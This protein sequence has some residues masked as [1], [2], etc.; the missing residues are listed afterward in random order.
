MAKWVSIYGDFVLIQY[1]RMEVSSNGAKTNEY[2]MR[3]NMLM[4]S[5]R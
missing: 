2:N 3:K 4:R 1:F 5:I